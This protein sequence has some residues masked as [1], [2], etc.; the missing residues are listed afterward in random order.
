MS[1]QINKLSCFLLNLFLPSAFLSSGHMAAPGPSGR[2]TGDRPGTRTTGH[3]TENATRRCVFLILGGPGRNRTTDTRFF[4][5]LFYRLSC[6]AKGGVYSKP[7]ANGSQR[8][9]SPARSGWYSTSSKRTFSNCPSR[10][11]QSIVSPTDRPSSAVPIG[12]RI[13]MPF[14]TW[15]MS[16]G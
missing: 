6:Q 7:V 3:T 8:K 4:N 5:P 14:A 16:F 9:Y 1:A 13:E 10:R 12:V 2:L 11:G 15:A